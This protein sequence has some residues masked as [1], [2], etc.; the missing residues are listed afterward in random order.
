MSNGKF[1]QWF[2]DAFEQTVAT[3]SLTSD[4]S[5]KQSWQKV[6]AEIHKMNKQKKRM[7]HFQLAIVVAASV[8]AG[9]VIFNPPAVTQAISPVFH[10]IKNWGNGVVNII[11]DS[12]I[13][14]NSEGALTTPPPDTYPEDPDHPSATLDSISHDVSFVFTLEEAKSKLSFPYPDLQ[15]IPERFQ[16]VSSEMAELAPGE[17]TDSITMT[18]RTANN[19]L[20]RIILHSF[21][22]PQ[23]SSSTGSVN[24]EVLTL[25][26]DIEVYF[27]P[28]RF[29]D[30]QFS[31][32]GLVMRIYGNLS[33]E[34]LIDM[35]E[36]LSN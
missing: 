15:R 4:E 25:K 24:T 16:L 23:A 12:N 32:N 14:P 22:Q 26:N 34:E 20:M 18:Y 11:F 33:K 29:N 10:S 13:Q 35:T 5:K 6:Q 3:S 2:D 17:K 36:S 28:G 7:R 27:T 30:I 9:A 8:T 19:D 21:S 31:Y 1:D